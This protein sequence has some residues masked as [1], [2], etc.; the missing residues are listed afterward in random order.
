MPATPELTI[1]AYQD[2]WNAM[3]FAAL[4]LLWDSAESDIYYVA[5]EMDQ[6]MYQWAEVAQYFEL[7]ASVV[8]SVN[9]WAENR[10]YKPLTENLTVATFDMHV[11]IT[12][13][14]A[15][16]QGIKPVG[17]DVRVSAILKQR[18]KQWRF[19]HYAEAPL[20]PLL[21]VRRA[22]AANVRGD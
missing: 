8:E 4:G 15:K 19:I 3:D 2:A 22:Y 21:F 18:D 1:D 14:S 20:G 10:R 7:T 16:T 17:V 13:S 5:E 6:P 9:L 12:M 11:D